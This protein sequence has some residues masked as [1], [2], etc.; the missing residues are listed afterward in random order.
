[1]RTR[2][3]T[4][5]RKGHS[6]SGNY[7]DFEPPYPPGPVIQISQGNTSYSYR[8]ENMSDELSV[9]LDGQSRQKENRRKLVLQ[10]QLKKISD[11]DPSF[12]KKAIQE[13]SQVHRCTHV[14]TEISLP[15]V[16]HIAR[17]QI[18][19]DRYR[20]FTHSHTGGSFQTRPDVIGSDP[21][22]SGVWNNPSY[23][24]GLYQTPD[25]FALLDQ[26]HEASNS[27]I[28][29][30]TLLGESI[31]EHGI[32]I[33][34]FK[35][36]LNPSSAVRVLLPR[37][38]KVWK[39]G[40]T[41][42]GLRKTLKDGSNAYLGYQFGVRPAIQEVRRALSAHEI[43]QGR[44]NWLSQNAGEFVPIRV[45]S[46]L[47]SSISNQNINSSGT[48]TKTLI[49]DDKS[50]IATISAWAKVRED[51]N[52]ASQWS[53]YTQ[54][55]GLQKVVGLA[56]E[57]VPLSFVI[58]WFTNAQE[59]INKYTSPPVVNPFYSM[60][61]L[62]HSTKLQL[63]E[64]LWISHGYYYNEDAARVLSPSAPYKIAERK[65][66]TYTRSPSLPTSSGFVD[67]SNLGLFHGITLGVMLLQKKL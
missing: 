27:L 61:G 59:Y 18:S 65:L 47:T 22:T 55:F 2:S 39:R 52:Y 30:S 43:V 14:K 31:V 66:S 19:G 34:A 64:S 50:T 53:A 45:R 17:R 24:A 29:S 67:F 49:C 9:S 15:D 1:M 25:W 7:Q 26:F 20:I 4:W 32:F 48:G 57:L 63:K 33:D 12:G 10:R 54:Y 8:S 60:R 37:L 62:C 51:L 23:T 3:K 13:F 11:V 28:P 36:V 21:L 42:G 5:V 35:I 46:T 6:G 40:M 16:F 56:W 58:D 41:L 44:L 38:K